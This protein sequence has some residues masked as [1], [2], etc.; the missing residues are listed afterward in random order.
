MFGDSTLHEL[1]GDEF[2][3]NIYTVTYADYG[4]VTYADYGKPS[5]L[6]KYTVH[7]KD[8]LFL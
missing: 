3:V 2:E 5:W 8:K 7:S 1:N 6:C 4:T